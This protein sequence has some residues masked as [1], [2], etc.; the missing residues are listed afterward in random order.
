LLVEVLRGGDAR[1]Q[2]EKA[3]DPCELVRGAV[4]RKSND[5]S[6]HG[7]TPRK[8]QQRLEEF[9]LGPGL[10]PTFEPPYMARRERE[11]IEPVKENESAWA[12]D[13]LQELSGGLLVRWRR[14][15]IDPAR[16]VLDPEDRA[17]NV[18]SLTDQ[19]RFGLTVLNHSSCQVP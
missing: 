5:V 4:E 9:G 7:G 13:L 8:V 11:A 10:L 2:G 1:R 18:A 15:R 12:R 16:P 6:V 3:D 17:E 19:N 14:P